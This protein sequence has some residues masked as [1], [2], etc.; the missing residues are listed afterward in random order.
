MNL[1]DFKSFR[2]VL[3]PS[4]VGSIPTHSRQCLLALVAA[5]LCTTAVPR[6]ARADDWEG[7]SPFRR[8][9]RSAVFPA[10]G[11]VTNGKYKKAAVLFTFETYLLTRVIQET[12]AARE[13]DRIAAGETD[14]G[15]MEVAE[16][17]AEDHYG[18]RRDLF[19]WGIVASFYGA[20]DAYVDAYL[21]D[22]EKDLE[23]GREL[24]AGVAEDGTSLEFGVRF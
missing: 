9:V 6:D 1:E 17:A 18:R 5:A 22:F 14:P 11:Q 16:A 7:P 12:R 13:W 19:F 2:R 10:W 20:I 4:E 24:F 15:R 23:E 21:G 3:I 8:A